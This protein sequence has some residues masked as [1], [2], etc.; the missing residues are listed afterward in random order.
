MRVPERG[1]AEGVAEDVLSACSHPEV[2]PTGRYR[3]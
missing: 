1:S 3:L 2:Q